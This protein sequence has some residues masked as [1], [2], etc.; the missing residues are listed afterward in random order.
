MTETYLQVT[1]D[2][3][4]EGDIAYS[5]NYEQKKGASE[6]DDSEEG[7]DGESACDYI[8]RREIFLE[9]VPRRIVVF[10]RQIDSK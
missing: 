4:E 2:I 1:L 10:S 9:V 7:R 6:D 3:T 8:V 5:R